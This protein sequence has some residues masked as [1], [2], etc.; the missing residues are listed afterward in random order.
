[1]EGLGWDLGNDL[2]GI[3]GMN[4]RISTRVWSV[5]AAGAEAGGFKIL[6]LVGQMAPC[7]PGQRFGPRPAQ[8]PGRRPVRVS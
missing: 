8:R 4:R 2:G 3:L 6:A 7:R 1:M 5:A